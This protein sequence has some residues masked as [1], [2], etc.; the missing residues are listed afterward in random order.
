MWRK[1]VERS[2]SR[3]LRRTCRRVRIE[4]LEDRQ[5]LAAMADIV[6]LADESLSGSIGNPPQGMQKGSGL[7]S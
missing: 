1:P 6:F 3:K 7:F 2:N 4:V 5:M